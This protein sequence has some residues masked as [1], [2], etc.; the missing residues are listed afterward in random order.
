MGW[1]RSLDLLSRNEDITTRET[2]DK[3]P[4]CRNDRSH[5]QK[6]WSEP[7]WCSQVAKCFYLTL[8]IT[9]AKAGVGKIFAVRPV[10][11]ERP[12]NLLLQFRAVWQLDGEGQLSTKTDGL[13]SPTH[14]FIVGDS[15]MLQSCMGRF[16]DNRCCEPFERCCLR[17]NKPLIE[18]ASL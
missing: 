16:M 12:R 3:I 7:A 9:V 11:F 15:P 17:E 14:L 6:G 13:N 2:A 18:H 5:P 10:K 8:M 1:F 4:Y